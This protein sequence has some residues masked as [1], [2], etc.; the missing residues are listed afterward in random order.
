[1]K[2]STAEMTLSE[3]EH[4]IR[5]KD[6][7]IGVIGLGYVGL[8]VAGIFAN[9]GFRVT[10][11]DLKR[12]RIETINAGQCPIDGKEPGL[13]ALVAD[14]VR[15]GK[16][17]ASTD[18]ERLADCDVVLISVETPVDDNHQPQYR[19]LHSALC[20]LGAVLNKG[21]LV[22]IE[23]TLAPGTMS[24]LVRPLLE[25]TSGMQVNHEIFLGHCP[26][27]VMP[28]KLLTNLRAMSRVCGGE[29]PETAR[30]MIALYRHI[31]K[32]DLDPA[33]CITAELVKTAENAY[34]DVNIAFANEVAL[35]CEAVGGD[36]WKVRD[37]VNKS[38]GRNM[39]YPGAG[40]GGHCI[41]KDPWLLASQAR[42]NGT[43][44]R[45]IPAARAVNDGMPHHITELLADALQEVNVPLSKARILILGYA[46]LEN[47]EDTRNSPSAAL[48]E[49]LT[50]LGAEVTIHDPYV[51]GYQG[52]VKAMT[53]GADAV[54][55]MVK[56]QDYRALNWDEIRPSLRH[57]ILID[58]RNSLQIRPEGYQIR[59]IGEAKDVS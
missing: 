48:V 26:E 7:H 29:P 30:A 11:I 25:D 33:D 51:P 55:L 36:V 42:E 20:A 44:V 14:V 15:A 37:L 1:M 57:P 49:G 38:P 27:R 52:D 2:S 39:L 43:P 13:A 31:V 56:H 19:A 16:L 17:Q 58:G 3:L 6:V 12:E 22:I 24:S 35:I 18:Y 47:S 54:L 8:P 46:Y 10:G 59:I 5:D 50:D 32:A 40:V 28:G 53:K 34:R 45:L 23:S 4:K 9:A 21:S 41:P